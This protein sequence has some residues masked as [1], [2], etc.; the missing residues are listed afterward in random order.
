V[1]RGPGRPPGLPALPA[2]KGVI[3]TAPSVISE[4][5]SAKGTAMKLK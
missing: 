1:P 3:S 4:T 5:S 2:G